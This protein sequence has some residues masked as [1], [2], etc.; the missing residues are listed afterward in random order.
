MKYCKK[1][2]ILYSTDVCPGCG[3]DVQEALDAEQ[4][5]DAPPQRKKA[6]QQWLVLIVGVPVF[7]WLIYLVIRLLSTGA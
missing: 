6:G 3:V 1:C 4:P 5:P 2:G 7:I